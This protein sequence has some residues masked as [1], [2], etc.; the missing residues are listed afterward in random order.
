MTDHFYKDFDEVMRLQKEFMN[1][2]AEKYSGLQEQ[3]TRNTSSTKYGT[4][5]LYLGYFC[6]SLVMEKTV[7]GFKKG[8]LYNEIPKTKN[9]SY[10][11]YDMDSEGKL[12]RIQDINK[13]GT[14]VET[15]IIRENNTAFSVKF[16]NKKLALYDGATTRTLYENEKLKR[17]DIID[18]GS[19]WSE[20][21]TYSTEN[22]NKVECKRYYYVP[23][24]AGSQHSI[25]I[26]E[27]GSP[28]QLWIIDI[29]LDSRDKVIK[30]EQYEFTGGKKVLLN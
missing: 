8:K 17:F 16:S 29:E 1:A 6:P 28:A 11:V 23:H 30:L 26:G 9:G 21:Y 18:S 10:V 3:V 4:Q 5:N 14:I 15:Y 13:Y 12:L 7:G 24:L 2:A 19:M 22:N 20:I 27:K 25:P